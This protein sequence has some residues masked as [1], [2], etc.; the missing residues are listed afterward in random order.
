MSTEATADQDHIG[1]NTVE[2]AVKGGI[3]VVIFQVLNMALRFGSNLVYAWLLAPDAFGLVAL[4]NVFTLGLLLFTDVG[5][6]ESIVRSTRGDEK[7]FLNTVWTM[8][9][10]RGVL[11]WLVCI[12]AAYPMSH[13][14]NE[15]E[16]MPLIA[17]SSFMLVFVGFQATSLGTMRRH[18]EVIDIAKLDLAGQTLGFL[19][20]LIWAL[21][22]PTAWALVA[23]TITTWLVR[24]I[25]SHFLQ[26]GGLNRMQWDWD[27]FWEVIDMGKW[28]F[29]STAFM[30]LA[31]QSDRLMLGAL[32]DMSTLGIYHIAISLAQ[33][34]E[35]IFMQ[36]S[37]RVIFPMLAHFARE[38]ASTV[39]HKLIQLRSNVLPFALYMIASLMV[40]AE[41]FF[42]VLYRDAYQLAGEIAPLLAAMFW[43]SILQESVIRTSIA[44]GSYSVSAYTNIVSFIFRLTLAYIG[45]QMFG[46]SGFIGGLILGALCGYGVVLTWL[47]RKKIRTFGQDLRY[48]G[49]LIAIALTYFGVAHYVV[50]ED[51]W[52]AIAWPIIYFLGMTAVIAWWGYGK[53]KSGA[54]TGG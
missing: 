26:K 30:F 54:L 46:I 39:K 10:V 48:T 38:D 2:K 22:S 45:F 18:L 23:A 34:P 44:M 7:R 31:T 35:I 13:Y 1:H 9:I 29:V 12:A 40:L 33:I 4:V 11:L 20:G 47:A 41:L 37:G 52:M 14:Y 49:A 50:P 5:L 51:S 8:Q 28:I 6:E 32:V 42:G 53:Y 43:V 3:W 36:L 17:A 16:L 24:L 21:I 15:P 19:A 25:A 27:A